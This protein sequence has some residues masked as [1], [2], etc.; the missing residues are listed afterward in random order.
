MQQEGS[1][2]LG[3]LAGMMSKTGVIGYVGGD[4]TYPNLVNIFEGYKQGAKLMNPNVKGTCF[5][6]R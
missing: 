3:A 1:F 5:I 4:V 2:L 6:F